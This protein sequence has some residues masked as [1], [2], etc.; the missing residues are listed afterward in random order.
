MQPV[1]SARVYHP[2]PEPDG[3][4]PLHRRTRRA[5]P[6]PRPWC[7]DLSRRVYPA[8]PPRAAR[9]ARLRRL[10]VVDRP[11]PSARPRRAPA[12]RRLR[13]SVARARH[14]PRGPRARTLEP[15]PAPPPTR[16]LRRSALPRD[17]DRQQRRHLLDAA[18]LRR[19]DGHNLG[20]FVVRA[21]AG[22]G[23][24]AG[25]PRPRRRARRLPRS[26]ARDH[27]RDARPQGL[28]APAS[29]APTRP[30]WRSPCSPAGC[31]FRS[32]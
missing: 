26:A 29:A 31:S 11:A 3:R 10:A 27:R 30:L 20:A 24:G 8:Q 13:G 16:D 21:R 6:G 18:H 22:H 7:V 25:A 15:G 28:D 4:R 1:G 2:R 19:R 17:G 12:A 9:R 32:R 23:L 5:T 14:R